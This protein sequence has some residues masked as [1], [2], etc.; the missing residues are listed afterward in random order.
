MVNDGD[1]YEVSLNARDKF[2]MSIFCVI[3]DNVKA[4]MSRRGQVYCDIADQFFCLVN[5]PETSSTKARIQYSECCEELINA[6]P[7]DLISNLLTV[8]QRFSLIIRHNLSATKS[9]NTRFSRAELY[10]VMVKN[11]IQWA[12]P[13]VEIRL[14]IFLT[15]ML[16]NCSAERSFTQLRHTK[17]E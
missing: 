9:G 16:T 11:N 15:L 7:E 5:V 17:S 10:R 6:Y 2:C 4:E 1:A 14:C 3:I 13:N 12:F 8:L